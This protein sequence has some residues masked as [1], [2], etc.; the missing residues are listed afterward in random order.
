MP[1]TLTSKMP[2][3]AGIALFTISSGQPNVQRKLCYISPFIYV[4][5]GVSRTRNLSDASGSSK[6][7]LG[8]GLHETTRAFCGSPNRSRVSRPN[9]MR[10]PKSGQAKMVSVIPLKLCF[11]PSVPARHTA[12]CDFCISNLVTHHGPSCDIR[13]IHH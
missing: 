3:P 13:N 11:A 2:L 9:S 5:H 10:R 1:D 7:V 8:R 6:G 12:F 4:V